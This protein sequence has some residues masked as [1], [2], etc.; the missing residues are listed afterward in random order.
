MG[1]YT[2]KID[3]GI[4]TNTKTFYLRA[5]SRG[6]NTVDQ[7][8][9]FVVCPKTGGVTVTPPAGYTPT[10]ID[11]TG[12]VTLNLLPNEQY[13]MIDYVASGTAANAAWGNW[14]IAD[15]FAGCGVFYEYRMNAD[16]T[17]LT[18]LQSP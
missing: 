15:V 10:T 5:I 18:Y 2:L 9:S 12:G 11:A 8:F 13:A 4:A 17:T 1:S 6:L 14:Q 16:A 3:K 7:P